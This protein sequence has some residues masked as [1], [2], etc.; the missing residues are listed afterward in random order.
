MY[1]IHVSYTKMCC[2]FMNVMRWHDA[3]TTVK[4]NMTTFNA[5]LLKLTYGFRKRIYNS[6]NVLLTAITNCMSFRD[7]NILRTW[8][9]RFYNVWYGHSQFVNVLM[10]WFYK[11]ISNYFIF[12][13]ILFTVHNV[14]ILFF[15][16]SGCNTCIC[17]ACIINWNK[18]PSGLIV[19]L[20]YATEACMG[21]V[22]GGILSQYVIILIV[23]L[24][25]KVIMFVN[26]S[27]I[28]N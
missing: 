26:L 1:T 28:N 15:I 14:Y 19:I 5:L 6:D 4:Y 18:I 13:N 12:C 7:S 22:Y 11:V 16:F 10:L 20:C 21:G 27:M 24:Y 17:N 2:A 25:K 8:N 23:Y 3:E 9:N